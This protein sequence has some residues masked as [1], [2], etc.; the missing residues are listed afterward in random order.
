MAK[1]KEIPECMISMTFQ[2]MNAEKILR[3]LR[4]FFILFLGWIMLLLS[5]LGLHEGSEQA[6]R[7][8]DPLNPALQ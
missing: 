1:L 8:R 3:L 7:P 5:F 6:G 2:L 4:L